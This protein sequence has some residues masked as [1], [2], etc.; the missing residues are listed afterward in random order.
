MTNHEQFIND[1]LPAIERA[2]M[3]AMLEFSEDCHRYP[4]IYCYTVQG[5]QHA[6]LRAVEALAKEMAINAYTSRLD[7]ERCDD[8]FQARRAAREKASAQKAAEPKPEVIDT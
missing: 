7:A 8:A 4:D 2:A 6:A 5:A 3:V 1:L